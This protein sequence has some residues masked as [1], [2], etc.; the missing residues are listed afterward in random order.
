MKSTPKVT[1]VVPTRNRNEY[2]KYSLQCIETYEYKYF[3]VLVSNNSTLKFY[4]ETKD[5]IDNE[6]KRNLNYNISYIAPPKPLGMSDHFE[7][8]LNNID[9]DYFIFHCDDDCLSPFCV[10]KSVE[11]AEANHLDSVCWSTWSYYHPDWNDDNF[12][13]NTIQSGPKTEQGIKCSKMVLKQFF[14]EFWMSILYPRVLNGLTSTKLAKKIQ[15]ENGRF[16]H[17]TMPDAAAAVNILINT[18]N[19]GILGGLNGLSGCAAK[20]GASIAVNYEKIQKFNQEYG[21]VDTLEFS[22]CKIPVTASLWIDAMIR[23]AFANNFTVK[24]NEFNLYKFIF[25]NIQYMGSNGADVSNLVTQWENEAAVALGKK[26]ANEIIRIVTNYSF[27]DKV[28]YYFKDPIALK[29]RILN[30]VLGTK[31]ISY[32]GYERCFSNLFEANKF[33]I[34]NNSYSR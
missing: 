26:Q 18:K 34:N 12:R 6:I 4:S 10:K 16:F 21:D 3:D 27:L 1:L 14:N 25:T 24:L 19:F 2:L 17:I 5:I 32:N 13:K 30:L 20:S 11:F 8:C 15:K 7:F 9:S 29:N 22:P 23:T 31:C 33:M 28:K